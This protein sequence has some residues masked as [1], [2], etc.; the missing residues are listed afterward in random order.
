LRECSDSQQ[1]LESIDHWD[2]RQQLS[3]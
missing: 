1:C 2:A 3:A